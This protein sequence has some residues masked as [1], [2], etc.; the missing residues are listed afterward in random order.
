MI[1]NKNFNEKLPGVW[2]WINIKLKM[3]DL[4]PSKVGKQDMRYTKN[5]SKKLGD[6]FFYASLD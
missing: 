1:L 2:D 5:N 4:C 6:C 3:L